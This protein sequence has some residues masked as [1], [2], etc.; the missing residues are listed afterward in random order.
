VQTQLKYARIERERR[1][2]LSAFPAHASAV[3]ARRLTDR[4]I[5]QTRVRLRHQVNT[6]GTAT[7][8]LTQKIPCSSAGA[9]Q[10][11]LTTMYLNAEEYRVFAELPARQ[12]EKTRY[13]V[14]PFGIDVF[15]GPLS[16]LILAEAEFESASE[17][18]SLVVPE[19]LIRE[20]SG[21]IR[22]TGGRLAHASSQEV[23]S[24]ASEYG[25][26]LAKPTNG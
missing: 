13:S 22:F 6:D 8:K 4:Y 18:E 25:V 2:I 7:F 11:F 3:Q 14:P 15:E 12:L 26:T 23:R 21:D 20:V 10:A 1:F 16:G 24:W 17:A 19:F 9:R 5:D